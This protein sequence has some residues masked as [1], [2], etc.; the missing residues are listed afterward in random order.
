MKYNLESDFSKDLFEN[1]CCNVIIKVGEEEFHAHS[2]ILCSRSTYFCHALSKRW[3][4]IENNKIV[5][6]K[7]NMRPEVFNAI[8]K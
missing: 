1:D 5:L 4:K 3:A 8:L 7:P 2:N 6:S